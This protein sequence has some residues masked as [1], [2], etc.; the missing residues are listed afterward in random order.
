MKE[1]SGYTSNLCTCIHVVH[2]SG[3]EDWVGLTLH[4]SLTW[5]TIF[6]QW[7]KSKQDYFAES[8][9]LQETMLKCVIKSSICPKFNVLYTF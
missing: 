6:K 3:R 5:I 1:Y 7:F 9:K 8:N 4:V 2:V